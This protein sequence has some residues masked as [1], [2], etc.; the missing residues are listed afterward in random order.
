MM[1]DINDKRKNRV[2]TNEQIKRAKEN[3]VSYHCCITVVSSEDGTSKRQHKV[4]DLPKRS[5]GTCTIEAETQQLYQRSI[6]GF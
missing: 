3:G 4:S 1:K 5:D 2:L 6:N